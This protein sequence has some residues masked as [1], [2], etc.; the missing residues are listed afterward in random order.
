MCKTRELASLGVGQG[1]RDLPFE[2][3]LPQGSDRLVDP[4]EGGEGVDY[5]DLPCGG[6]EAGGDF[7]RSKKLE[8]GSLF[9]AGARNMNGDG[10]DA[11]RC[12]EN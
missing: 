11:R 2:G 10:A 9:R 1:F 7:H 3:S 12:Q 6:T 8:A 5:G 4:R